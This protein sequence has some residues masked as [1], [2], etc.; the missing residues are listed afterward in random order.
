MNRITVEE[1]IN[2][3]SSDELDI[4]MELECNSESDDE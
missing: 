3:L 1:V 4:G 2:M